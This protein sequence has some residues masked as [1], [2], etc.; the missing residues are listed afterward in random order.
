[1]KYNKRGC[2]IKIAASDNFI[3]FLPIKLITHVIVVNI[4]TMKNMIDNM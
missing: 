2:V 1:M 4:K 3:A